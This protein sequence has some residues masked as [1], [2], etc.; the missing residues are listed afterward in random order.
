MRSSD[1]VFDLLIQ[2]FGQYET[3][4]VPRALV[5][6]TGDIKTALLLSQI[7]YWSSL[8]EEDDGWFYKSHLDWEQEIALTRHEVARS[9]EDLK[10]AEVVETRVAQVR[11]N[12]PPTVHYRIRIAGFRQ[13]I[14]KKA[15]MDYQKNGN[16]IV[17]KA[18]INKEQKNTTEEYEQKT[19]DASAAAP[20]GKTKTEN[21]NPSPTELGNQEQTPPSSA[22]PPDAVAPPESGASDLDLEDD[23]V[24]FIGNVYSRNKRPTP[25]LK[26]R[27]SAWLVEQLRGAEANAGPIEFRTALT[28]YVLEDSAWL[29]ENKWP[30]PAFLKNIDTVPRKLTAKAAPPTPPRA[31]TR[32]A[33]SLGYTGAEALPRYRM[34]Q[35]PSAGSHG[36]ESAGPS[37]LSEHSRLHSPAKPKGQ[38]SPHVETMG[39]I[40]GSHSP[41]GMPSEPPP[42]VES[43][44]TERLCQTGNS[45]LAPEKQGILAASSEHSPVTQISHQQSQLRS[46]AEGL[47]EKVSLSDDTPRYNISDSTCME[48]Q[49]DILRNSSS[50]EPHSSGQHSVGEIDSSCRAIL[51]LTSTKPNHSTDIHFPDAVKRWNVLLPEPQHEKYWNA[52]SPNAAL[53]E[54]MAETEFVD[55]FDSI[56]ATCCS[57]IAAGR[58][59]IPGFTWLLKTSAGQQVNWWRV[60]H[61]EFAWAEV[62]ADAAKALSRPKS[63]IE[64]AEENMA[65]VLREQE[66]KLN[67]TAK[68]NAETACPTG[69][70]G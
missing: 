57:V 35:E 24:T 60:L 36:S 68:N 4:T 50:S 17:K 16:L 63:N 46:G 21:Q 51:P 39:Q 41:L 58:Y 42:Q 44:P 65:K 28:D 8:K 31:D 26:T 47:A 5:T 25:K 1:P 29:R 55:N 53:G 49:P 18:A 67:D 69:T 9:T 56:C 13:W 19:T 52:R 54:A 61:G 62:G 37:R 23:L 3:L 11:G 15:A 34:D 20:S 32:P 10:A 38:I 59:K 45:D 2:S 22:A 7:I 6:L 48:T 14:V 64:L 27:N 12:G 43:P 33:I 40:V 70:P 30:L 66:S